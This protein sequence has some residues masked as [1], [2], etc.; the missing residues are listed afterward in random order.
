M[1]FTV[2]ILKRHNGQITASENV[3]LQCDVIF[4]F[5]VPPV[6]G[7]H[8]HQRCQWWFK[9]NKFNLTSHQFGWDFFAHIFKHMFNTHCL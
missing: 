7:V 4:V 9:K 1:A 6:D 2:S 5:H 8:Y 3:L